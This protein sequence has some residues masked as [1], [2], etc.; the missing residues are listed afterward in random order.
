VITAEHYRPAVSIIM[1]FETKMGARAEVAQ[2][3]KFAVDKLEREIRENYP[4]ES[5]TIVIQK[6]K[7]VI[8]DLNFSTY[9]KSIAI[10]ISPLFEKILYLDLE[11]EEKIIID[12]S[13]EI[14]DLVYAK[15]E[16]HKYLV[17]LLSGRQYKV[18]IGNT[19]TFIRI[20]AN[21]PDHVDAMIR[22][23]SEKVSNF[24]DSSGRKQTI[25]KKFFYETDKTLSYLLNMYQLPVFIVGA[26]KALGYF[27][28]I[29]VNQKNISGYI[30]GNYEDATEDELR[31]LL[32]AYIKDWKK[33]KMKDLLQRMESAAGAG[34][35]SLGIQDVW[36][37][38]SHKKGCLLIVE[39]NFVCAAE[40][41]K[42]EDTIYEAGGSYNKFSYIQDAVDDV[43]EKVLEYGGDVEFVDEG[44]LG[45]YQHIALIQYY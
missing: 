44:M 41:G 36:R 42:T 29:S 28:S 10:F 12:E 43:I 30:H 13:F 25:L 14:R 45:D 8:T 11:V 5:G 4:N 37:E 9:K 7:R 38:A 35:L 22:D 31:N 19:S 6:L 3:L 26:K 39:K 23:I 24:S 15:K 17:L 20:K 27:K 34:K 32:D 18:Y 16:S 21:G 33:V 40:H 2:H 1:P